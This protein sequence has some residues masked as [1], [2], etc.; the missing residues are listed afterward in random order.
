MNEELELLRK[1]VAAYEDFITS[2]ISYRNNEYSASANGLY[3]MW[4]ED[5]QLED[6]SEGKL[7]TKMVIATEEAY[8][9]NWKKQMK[10]MQ[11][12]KIEDT[13]NV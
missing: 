10:D 3:C 4:R 8:R 1:K 2:N 13:N 7:V 12:K 5:C 9:E 11:K 6:D